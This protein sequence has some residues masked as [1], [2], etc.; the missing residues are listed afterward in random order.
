[1][2][3]VVK[4]EDFHP[5]LRCAS[6]HT[7]FVATAGDKPPEVTKVAAKVIAA[8]QLIIDNHKDG[9]PPEVLLEA[10]RDLEAATAFKDKKA[11][12]K[13]E[14]GYTWSFLHKSAKYGH[15][16]L[17]TSMD[18]CD[19][20]ICM[21]H[22]K[23]CIVGA[24]VKELLLAQVGKHDDKAKK[25]KGYEGDDKGSIAHQ[26]WVLLVNAGIPIRPIKKP[27]K[28]VSQYYGSI[29]KHKFAGSDASI[30]LSIYDLA[31]DIVYPEAKRTLGGEHYSKTV[32]EE[33]T[34]AK[35][36]WKIWAEE[37]WP[38]IKKTDGDREELAQNVEIIGKIMD[39]GVDNCFGQREPTP[40]HPS[41]ELPLA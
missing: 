25:R 21:L 35:E 33:Y 6:E 16:C 34:K 39:E 1:M 17:I 40:V 20:V 30:M 5:P 7:V 18:P 24:M 10:R 13:Y 31:L 11:K 15:R 8:A 26:L 27:T 22:L 38:A 36:V 4:E 23:L 14:M 28:K 37:L 12:N 41:D 2:Y 3:V 9:D 32:D 29:S 19:Y